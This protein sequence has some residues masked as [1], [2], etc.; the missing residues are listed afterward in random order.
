MGKMD[1]IKDQSKEQ[2]KIRITDIEKEL[3]HLKNELK[4]AHKIEKPH[5]IR[6]LKKEKAR[7]LTFL[8]QIKKA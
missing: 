2:L 8:T 7:I 4:T 5:M 1:K 6:E 3:Y